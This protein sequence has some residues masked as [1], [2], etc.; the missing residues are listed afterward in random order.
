[1]AF[2]ENIAA[3]TLLPVETIS[4]ALT[5]APKSIPILNG[6]YKLA[7]DIRETSERVS[8]NKTQCEQLS[9]RIDTMIGFLGQRDLSHNLNDAMHTALHRFETFLRRCLEFIS[10]FVETSWFKRIVNNKDYEK[11]FQ[12]LNRELTQYANDL[13]FGIGLGNMPMNK[14]EDENHRPN[15]KIVISIY[16]LRFHKISFH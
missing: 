7:T 10:T 1:M 2:A 3:A 4:V 15:I 6:I 9:E 12:D 11:K 8:A 5:N 16:Y 13:N 14:K